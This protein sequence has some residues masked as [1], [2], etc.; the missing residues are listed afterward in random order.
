MIP[1][2]S[3]F[4]FRVE[5]FFSFGVF[6][7]GNSSYPSFCGFGTW[8]DSALNKL[9]GRR[10]LKISYG[11]ELGDR[12]AEYSKWSQLAFR[13]ACLEANLDLDPKQNKIT[14]LPEEVI[15][16]WVPVA[17]ENDSISVTKGLVADSRHPDLNSN[18]ICKGNNAKEQ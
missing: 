1:F 18:L 3:R 10:L 12:D 9:S 6:A 17:R 15:T 14:D 4:C 5:F 13:Q 7:L 8:L 11:D 16:R 2:S